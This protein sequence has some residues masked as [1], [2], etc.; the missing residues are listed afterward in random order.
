MKKKKVIELVTLL[1]LS[2]LPLL[3]IVGCGFSDT[4]R[5]SACGDNDT[6]VGLYASGTESGIE[7]KSCVGPAGILGFGCD[8]ACWPTECLKVKSS[9][10]SETL[11]GCVYYYNDWGCIGKATEE[12]KGSYSK[13]TTCLGIACEGEEYKESVTDSGV[14]ATRTSTCLGISCGEKESTN[15]KD[16]NAQMPRQFVNG[17]WS[18]KGN[19]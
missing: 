10:S 6:R 9:S 14:S 18:C 8:T 7:Y 5:C 19:E 3:G 12:S 11:S 17:C 1:S 16:Y 4:V 13:D 15:S 2:L